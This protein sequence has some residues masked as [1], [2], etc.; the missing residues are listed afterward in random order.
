MII[1]ARITGE[2]FYL[3]SDSDRKHA[4]DQIMLKGAAISGCALPQTEFFA[5]IIADQI[6]DFIENF[7]FKEFTIREIILSLLINSKG[8]I[9]FPS[10]IELDRVVFNGNCFNVDYLSKVLSN[11]MAIRAILDQKFKNYIDGR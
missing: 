5:D 6:C 4:C 2:S 3:L 11:Y 7:G 10:G 9:K 1:E 8:G